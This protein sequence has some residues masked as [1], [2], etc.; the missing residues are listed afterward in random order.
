MEHGNMNSFF[1]SSVGRKYLMGVS[2][3]GLIVFVLV[4]MLGNLLIFA[5]PK[6]Y[7]L[8]AHQ[9]EQ[10]WIVI[11]EIGLA[12]LFVLH[13]ALAF[14]L[15]V[16]NYLSRSVAYAR[17]S[18][19]EKQ[20]ALYQRTLL[21]QGALILVFVILHLITFKFGSYYEISYDEQTVRDLFRLVV[22]VF[23]QP[24]AFAWYLVALAV[25]FFHLLHGLES[26]LKSLGLT[27]STI[28]QVWVKRLSWMYAL[29]TVAGYMSQPIYVFFF[30]TPNG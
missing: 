3:L 8:Y 29:F 9:L 5:G 11:L 27:E 28:V 17:S 14:V 7:N 12:T 1:I 2:G 10:S 6:T 4:H 19:G 22:E 24:L 26:A 15:S 13:I 21:A 23:Q 30:Y 25:L 18:W 16:K 20:T